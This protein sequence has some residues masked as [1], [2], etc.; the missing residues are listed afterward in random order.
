V[1]FGVTVSHGP[2]VFEHDGHIARHAD[3]IALSLLHG[4]LDVN[5]EGK[6][7][8]TARTHPAGS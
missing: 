5:G 8:R 6:C 2:H 4:A 7:G 3:L 1:Q